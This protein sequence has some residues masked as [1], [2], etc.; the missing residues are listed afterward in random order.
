MREV[1]DL[2]PDGR[3]PL[4]RPVIMRVPEKPGVYSFWH[5][6]KAR[7]IYV[8]ESENLRSRLLQ[9][10]RGS[11]NSDLKSWIMCYFSDIEICYMEASISQIKIL[12]ESFI[13]KLNPITNKKGVKQ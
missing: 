10:Y 7:C 1:S 8:G 9:H 3:K 12:E 2:C 4:R 5:K 13:Q 6:E 11:H